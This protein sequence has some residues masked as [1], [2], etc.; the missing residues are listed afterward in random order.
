MHGPK[1]SHAVGRRADVV[2]VCRQFDKLFSYMF[3]VKNAFLAI[4]YM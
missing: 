1:S 2:D 3:E 4:F